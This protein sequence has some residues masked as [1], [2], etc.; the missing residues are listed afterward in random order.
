MAETKRE[1]FSEEAIERVLSPERLDGYLRVVRPSAWIAVA[2]LVVFVAGAL[3]WGFTGSF[4]QTLSA[5]G[6]VHEDGSVVSYI[7]V[8]QMP[9]TP[10][11]GCDARVA[12]PDGT[13]LEGTV[14]EVGARPLSQEE[15][16]D[17]QADAW[18][19]YLLATSPFG[20]RVTIDAAPGGVAADGAPTGTGDTVAEV[21]IVTREEKLI[22]FLLN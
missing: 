2:A 15:V 4:S 20:Y 18:M 11:V 5:T 3:I 12:M 1:L 10:L 7:P 13:V 8:E 14:A 17:E 16:A 19:A 9:S 21:T 22:S 6:L